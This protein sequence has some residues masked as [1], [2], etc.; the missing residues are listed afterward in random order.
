MAFVRHGVLAPGTV[1]AIETNA[2]RD[3]IEVLNRD[4]AAEIY[5][6]VDGVNPA[7]GGDDCHVVAAT[8]GGGVEVSVPDR[9]GKT[10]VR[11]IA[12]AAVAFSLTAGG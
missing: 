8:V 9:A 5:F 6:R 7:V 3:S 4:G 2:D 12:A 1:T 10:D 11:L